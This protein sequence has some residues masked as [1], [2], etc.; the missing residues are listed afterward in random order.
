M[1]ARCLMLTFWSLGSIS[2]VNWKRDR[3]SSHTGTH[4]F[5]LRVE[6][7]CAGTR[8]AFGLASSND[9]GVSKRQKPLGRDV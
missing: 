8:T 4:S 9:S 7:S 6:G 5:S 3:P 2:T 1:S